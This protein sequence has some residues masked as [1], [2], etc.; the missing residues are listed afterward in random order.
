MWSG[1]SAG[2]GRGGKAYGKAKSS[3]SWTSASWDSTWDAG[4][5]KSA[6]WNSTGDWSQNWTEEKGQAKGKGG[7]PRDY[8]PRLEGRY[9]FSKAVLRPYSDEQGCAMYTNAA[10]TGVAALG[11]DNLRQVLD[12][13]NSELVRRPPVGV[14]TISGSIKGL[15]AT[16]DSCIEN[17]DLMTSLKSLAQLLKSR[18]GRAFLDA[19]EILTKERTGNV[20]QDKLADALLCW[21][22]FLRE[23]KSVLAAALPKVAVS[24]SSLYLGS[25]QILEATT[26]CNALSNWSQKVPVTG[27]NQETLAHWQA[28]PKDLQRL[29]AFLLASMQLRH[30]EGAAWLRQNGLGG[31]S[32]EEDA[33][34]GVPD[35]GSRRRRSASSSSTDSSARRKKKAAKKEKKRAKEDK[36]E[37]SGVPAVVSEAKKSSTAAP[38]ASL[39]SSEEDAA[40][41]EDDAA[42]S[43][44]DTDK[45]MRRRKGGSESVDSGK[46][47]KKK[48]A[49]KEKKRADKEGKHR[50]ATPLSG[51]SGPDPKEKVR[52][53]NAT[54]FIDS[55]DDRP[56]QTEETSA[57]KE[58]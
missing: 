20:P 22:G 46:H 38:E 8:I 17:D 40:A 21:L 48:T 1:A 34:W 31:D 41:C 25:M 37:G 28:V 14:S 24:T 36:K 53:S 32:D 29:K 44:S 51:P 16:L 6:D 30:T 49:K 19:C 18:K 35:A 9:A 33:A 12:W 54:G 55:Q 11:K 7:Q 2:R 27:S 3:K 57:T 23:N 13:R 26:M 42:Y 43:I 4:K 58:P 5:G 56:G 15:K 52:P 45:D 47:R 10:G 50:A 39:L